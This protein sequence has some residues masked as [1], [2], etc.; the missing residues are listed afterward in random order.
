MKDSICGWIG[1]ICFV[2][3]VWF[4]GLELGAAKAGMEIARDCIAVNGFRLENVT[5][6]CW[7]K[8]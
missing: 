4:V 6:E 8:P 7:L 1:V 5:F 2:L 3:L